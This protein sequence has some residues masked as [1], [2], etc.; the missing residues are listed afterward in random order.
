MRANIQIPIKSYIE[1]QRQNEMK[2]HMLKQ[3]IYI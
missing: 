1:L 2:K 3:R